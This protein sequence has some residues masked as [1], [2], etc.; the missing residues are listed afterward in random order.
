MIW[1]IVR[2]EIM[3]N[4]LSLRFMLSLILII[5]LFAASSF[6]FIGSYRQQSQDYWEKTNKNLSDLSGSLDRL[7][8]L[9]FFQQQVFRKP[10]FLSLCVEGYEKSFPNYV[11]FDIFTIGLPEVR[12][13]VN[14]TFPHFSD[15]NWVFIISLILSFVA[16]VFTF[17]SMSGEKEAGTLRLMLA[18]TIP[19]YNIL[20]GKYLGA[21][22]TLCIP[23]LIGLLASLIIV[24]TSNVSGINGLEWLKMLII[25]ILSLLY[26]S[27][28][29]FLGIFISSR[30]SHSA[31]SMVALLLIWVSL[32]ILIP[33]MGR[34]ISDM[35]VKTPTRVELNKNIDEADREIWDNHERYGKNA[36]NSTADANDPM[37][38]LPARSRL[39]NARSNT[40]NQIIDEHHK[41]MIAQ[42]LTGR[43][44]TC[45]SPTAVYRRAAEAIV[46]VGIGRCADFYQQA[47]RYQENLK[48]FIR[49]KDAEDPKS[50]HFI[51]DE[52]CSR[53][54]FDWHTIS[55]KPVDF[56]IVP[57]FQ[58]RDLAIGQSLKLAIWDI[59]LLILFNLVFFAGS[60][61][62]FL[63]YDVR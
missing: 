1:H 38:N 15:V 52:D 43:N 8:D 45:L 46:G 36:G 12:S 42:A 20:L 33:S 10:K 50:R 7:N 60:F 47:K 28:F 59:G 48:E 40:K 61:V 23:L 34:T 4:F 32:V 16:F 31:N 35:F 51:F 37:M 22:L 9:A 44:Y 56:D 62:S 27:L 39:Y 29:V 58:E 57:K 19:R 24:I 5:A 53:G 54:S 49:S 18:N 26:L 25:V 63:R 6:I 30:A 21:M 41:R 55:K 2:K 11:K 17:D 3:D 13:S 14:F